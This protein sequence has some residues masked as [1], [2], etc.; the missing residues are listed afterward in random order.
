[1]CFANNC[2]TFSWTMAPSRGCLKQKANPGRTGLHLKGHI[3]GV[4]GSF[5]KI[6]SLVY[7]ND[8]FI[9]PL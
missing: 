4:A 1:M 2:P 8:A 3:L 6:Q 9:V 5:V 7:E